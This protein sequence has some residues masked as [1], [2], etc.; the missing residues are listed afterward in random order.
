LGLFLQKPGIFRVLASPAVF[1]ICGSALCTYRHKILWHD[2]ARPLPLFMVL[3]GLLLVVQF[4]RHGPDGRRR[5]LL[6][7]QISL[8]V[9]AF[10]LLGKIILNSRIYHYGFVLAMPATLVLVVALLDWLPAAISTSGGSGPVFRA[11]ALS[12]LL[13]TAISTLSVQHF[14]LYGKNYQVGKGRDAFWADERGRYVNAVIDEIAGR[15]KADDTLVVLPEGVTINFLCRL[16]NPTP[17]LFFMPFD[18]GL[19]GEEQILAS[20]QNHPPDW[21]AVVPKNTD[22]YGY[23]GF[24]VDYGQQITAWIWQNYEEV[25]WIGVPSLEKARFGILLLRKKHFVFF[26]NSCASV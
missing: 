17:Y 14:F 21:I 22:E 7:R 13:V 12:L 16:R 11:A 23:R 26:L 9:F 24:G 18:V 19:F 25:W 1:F 3:L 8:T 6:M 10:A 20:F 2:A 5:D 15:A 4:F